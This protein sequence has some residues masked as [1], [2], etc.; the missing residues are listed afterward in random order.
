[1]IFVGQFLRLI[2]VVVLDDVRTMWMRVVFLRCGL[3]LWLWS[4][5]CLHDVGR[6][7][8]VRCVFTFCYCLLR[9]FGDLVKCF[10]LFV[11]NV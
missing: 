1:M 8:G 5:L 7:D 3:D 10:H 9:K 11:S 6:C 2:D 4:L